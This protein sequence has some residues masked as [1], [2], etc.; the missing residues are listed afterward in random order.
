MSSSAAAAAAAATITAT[1]T[2]RCESEVFEAMLKVMGVD[3]YDPNVRQKH[4]KS[5]LHQHNASIFLFPFI[6]RW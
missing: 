5:S 3:A 2:E 6:N 4:I 1:V